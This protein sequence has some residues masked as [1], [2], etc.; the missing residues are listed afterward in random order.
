MNNMF[1]LDNQLD[2]KTLDLITKSMSNEDIEKSMDKSS[3]VQV[4]RTVTR[5]G[6]TFQQKFWVKPDQVKKTDVVLKGK[7]NL[8]TTS[9]QANLKNKKVTPI[10]MSVYDFMNHFKVNN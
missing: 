2:R 3:L 10:G 1:F 6:K 7:E 4:E 5:G 9:S 8:N